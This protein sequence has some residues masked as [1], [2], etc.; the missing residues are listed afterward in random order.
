MYTSSGINCNFFANSRTYFKARAV[1]FFVESL[2]HDRIPIPPLL[3]PW[4]CASISYS[5]YKVRISASILDVSLTPLL[6]RNIK[7]TTKMMLLS[8]TSWHECVCLCLCEAVRVCLQVYFTI[9][10]IFCFFYFKFF[11]KSLPGNVAPIST[12]RWQKNHGWP[13]FKDFRFALFRNS[14]RKWIPGFWSC[15]A[16]LETG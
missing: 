5:E 1:N 13:E 12:R 14:R 7:K 8:H 6:T 3:A 15:S 4:S 11:W 10:L 9:K 2:Y 16:A